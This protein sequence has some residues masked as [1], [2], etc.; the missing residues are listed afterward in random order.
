MPVTRKEKAKHIGRILDR[1][2]PG[3]EIPLRHK[4]PFTLLVAVILSAQCTDK[5]VNRVTPALFRVAGTP[6]KMAQL[7]LA[8]LETL[9][10]PCGLAPTK[11]RHIRELSRRLCADF[12]GKV[13]DTFEELESLPGVG[14]K[15][16]SVVMAQAFHQPAFPVDTHIHRLAYRWGISNGK[17]VVKTESDLKKLFPADEWHRRHL[18]IIYYGRQFCPAR[19]HQRD[20]CEVCRL[21]GIR[22]RVG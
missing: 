5:T 6:R 15:T 13:P 12:K 7:P 14:H 3:V 10:R 20:R 4:N 18:Q 21:H 2:Y 9:I 8:R 1:L 16:A 22:S 17:D 11:S 19:N